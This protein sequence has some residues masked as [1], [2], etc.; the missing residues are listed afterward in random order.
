MNLLPVCCLNFIFARPTTVKKGAGSRV[1]V[2]CVTLPVCRLQL[3]HPTL[4]TRS[5]RHICKDLDA[6]NEQVKVGRL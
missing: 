2:T 4:F 5:I 3:Q 1:Y 6:L